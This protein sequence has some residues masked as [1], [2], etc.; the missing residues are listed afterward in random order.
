MHQVI[1][2]EH[3]NVKICCALP[4]LTTGDLALM[5]SIPGTTIVDPCD[6]LDSAQAVP[7]M[8]DHKG[9]VYM[10]LP[11]GDVPLVLDEY[12]YVFEPCSSSAKPS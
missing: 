10:R 7:Q 9:P 6:A 2:E 12:D 8:A 11:R 3:L 4:G 5:R 1:A